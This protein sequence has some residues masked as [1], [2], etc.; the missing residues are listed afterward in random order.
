MAKAESTKNYDN[1]IQKSN[2]KLFKDFKDIANS[3]DFYAFFESNGSPR[4]D[5]NPRPAD[6][7]KLE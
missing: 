4:W 3:K 1:T 2:P 5:L 7:L 6:V